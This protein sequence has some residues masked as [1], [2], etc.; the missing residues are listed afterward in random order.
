MFPSGASRFSTRPAAAGSVT[1]LKITG[2]S[3]PATAVAAP[4][5]AGVAIATM[6]STLLPTNCWQMVLMVLVSPWAFW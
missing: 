5:A 6:A 1:A 4:C 3:V 2:I